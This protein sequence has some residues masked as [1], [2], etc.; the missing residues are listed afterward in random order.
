MSRASELEA[1]RLSAERIAARWDALLN[2]AEEFGHHVAD[3]L[4]TLSEQLLAEATYIS[5]QR[6]SGW[7]SSSDA[8]T[9]AARILE[10]WTAELTEHVKQDV[11][12]MRPPIDL[13][14]PAQRKPV[15]G[16]PSERGQ[17]DIDRIRGDW[18]DGPITPDAATRVRLAVEAGKDV[19]GKLDA[20]FGEP[21][22]V[23]ITTGGFEPHGLCGKDGPRGYV[24]TATCP[25]CIAL[26]DAALDKLPPPRF[27]TITENVSVSADG[28]ETW[29]GPVTAWVAETADPDSKGNA[30]MMFTEP[31]E[32]PKRLTFA[33]VREHGMARARGADHRS[34]SQVDAFRQCGVQ[35]AL[36]DLNSAP[37]WWNVGGTAVHYACEAISRYVYANNAADAQITSRIDNDKLWQECFARSISETVVASA[38][39]PS[40][41]RAAKSGAEGYDWWRVEGA[42]MV[43]RWIGRLRALYDDGW[44]IATINGEAAIEVSL[45]MTIL[46]AIDQHHGNI[47]VENIIDLIMARDNTFLII[48]TKS[49]ASAPTSTHQLGQYAWALNHALDG[50][51]Y[52]QQNGHI[53]GAWWFARTDQLTYDANSTDLRKL[54]PWDE[55]EYLISTMDAAER[56]GLY[57]PNKSKSD[58]FGCGSCGVK[59][60]CPVGPR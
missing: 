5:E 53:I 13:D 50:D 16:V 33:E 40:E 30:S 15:P 35:Y 10:R 43:E 34:Y 6:K 52:F 25:E 41:W 12:P 46:A 3:V 18:P 44:T 29:H 59:A 58:R 9:A 51:G 45:P 14:D 7:K 23:H 26:F 39:G 27:D 48:D 21:A 8:H 57:L 20:A 28:G 1:K 47:K 31:S 60:L 37:A 56:Q 42:L 49:G 55:I 11:P 38:K 19:D 32:P 2:A 36:S 22:P 54:H 17:S 4:I 24:G